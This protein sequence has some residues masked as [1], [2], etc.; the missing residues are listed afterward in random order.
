M[1]KSAFKTKFRYYLHRSGY[2]QK[3]LAQALNLEASG[4]SHRL[5][6]NIPIKLEFLQRVC[7]LL[8]VNG[9]EK[10]ELFSLAGIQGHI[11]R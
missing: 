8:E 1:N 11:Q 2:N 6:G 5:S 4:I 10:Q 3:Q 7:E 9:D